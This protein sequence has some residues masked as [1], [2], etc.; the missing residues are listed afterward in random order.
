MGSRVGLD[1]FGEDKNLLALPGYKPR[2]VQP[3]EINAKITQTK[4]TT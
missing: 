1:G 2:T 4:F 3:V